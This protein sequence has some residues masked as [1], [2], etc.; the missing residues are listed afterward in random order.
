MHDDQNKTNDPLKPETFEERMAR[1]RDHF[2]THHFVRRPP[3]S[4]KLLRQW[5][6]NLTTSGS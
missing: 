4:R 6:K 3:K 1:M 5:R 2:E